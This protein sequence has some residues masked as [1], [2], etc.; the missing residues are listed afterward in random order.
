M[1]KNSSKFIVLAAFILFVVIMFT[2]SKTVKIEITKED[3]Q[4]DFVYLEESIHAIDDVKITLSPNMQDTE[5]VLKPVNSNL[6]ESY[7]PVYIS[8]GQTIKFKTRKGMEY[9]LGV[10][11][12]SKDKVVEFKLK[13]VR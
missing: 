6:E 1:K 5:I 10:S 8:H 7:E 2:R 9:K 3:M 4:K 12:K 13:N 11:S